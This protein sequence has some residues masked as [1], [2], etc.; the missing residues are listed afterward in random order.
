MNY[1]KDFKKFLKDH[2]KLDMRNYWSILPHI[3]TDNDMHII[4]GERDNGKTF[5]I[6]SFI[7]FCWDKYQR[8]S[9]LIRRYSE[10]LKQKNLDKLFKDHIKKELLPLDY[11]DII[12]RGGKFYRSYV[13]EEGE[14]ITESS[15]FMYT[16]A[17]NQKE[18]SKGTFPDLNL[19]NVFFDEFLTREIYLANEVVN[20]FNTLS[21]VIRETPDTLVWMVGNTV[22]WSCPYFREMGIE[23]A[24]K[25]NPGEMREYIVSNDTTKELKMMLEYTA[26]NKKRQKKEHNKWFAFNNPQLK[27]ITTGK[28]EMELY[29]HPKFSDKQKC[30]NRDVYVYFEGDIICLQT[31][32]DDNYGVYI[33]CRPYTSDID[34]RAIRVYSD[35][36][37]MDGV[38]KCIIDK[39]DKLDRFIWSLYE[40][41]KFLYSDNTTGEIIR[42]FV[43]FLKTE[44]NNL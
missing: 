25:M 28:W 29:P 18:V 13:S 17:L 16:I 39:Q 2:K 14:R 37:N 21:T 12:Y 35:V 34:E 31:M 8:P 19:S 40:R 27:M 42:N 15:P 22:N 3:E 32:Y 36:D 30:I 4:F 41:K 23:S 44:K 11:N 38:Y 9:V 5:G 10:T 43:N 6:L 33:L 1:L 7:L 20:F 26:S 24:R